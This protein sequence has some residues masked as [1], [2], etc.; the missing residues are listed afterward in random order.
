MPTHHDETLLERYQREHRVFEGMNMSEHTPGKLEVLDD[1]RISVTLPPLIED[2]GY[3]SHCVAMTHGGD[4]R[5]NS[6]ANARRLAACWNACEGLSAEQLERAGTLDRAEVS[7]N[8]AISRTIKTLADERDRLSAIN[9]ELLEALKACTTEEGPTQDE[10]NAGFAGGCTLNGHRYTIAVNEDR[11]PLVRWDVLKREAKAGKAIKRKDQ[12]E[13][14][15]AMVDADLFS[16]SKGE[17]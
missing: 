13:D 3:S 7:R 8:V 1:R 4:E 2:G 6:H 9:A 5:V 15:I 10:L 11:Q 16:A 14:I 17:T 12:S